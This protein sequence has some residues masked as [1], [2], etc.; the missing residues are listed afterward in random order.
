M[1]NVPAPKIRDDYIVS[2]SGKCDVCG[3][4]IFS[5]YRHDFVT[6]E[7]GAISLDGGQ[8][9]FRRVGSIHGYTDTSIVMSK[10]A[11]DFAVDTL[12]DLR[13]VTVGD[14][15]NEIMLCILRSLFNTAC[16]TVDKWRDVES[17]LLTYHGEDVRSAV[18]WG[19]DTGRNDVGIV[20]AVIRKVDEAG[21]FNNKYN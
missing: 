12:T 18:E 1:T 9:Y 20:N 13:S 19:L 14:E 15:P 3:D 7:C 16:L 4:S 21:F 10:A 2:N 5:S 11:F 17:M 6:C 8:D